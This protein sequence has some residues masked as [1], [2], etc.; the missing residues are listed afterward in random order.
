MF[1]Q[2]EREQDDD[3]KSAI[4]KNLSRIAPAS[5]MARLVPYVGPVKNPI[6]KDASKAIKR[7]ARRT[8]EPMPAGL[9]AWVKKRNRK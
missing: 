4:F 8:E 3:V 5:F 2:L 9:P 7:I 6:N 1:R